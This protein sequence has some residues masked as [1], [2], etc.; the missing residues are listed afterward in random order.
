MFLRLIRAPIGGD[1]EFAHDK[2]SSGD[3]SADRGN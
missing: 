3:A 1:E 2:T